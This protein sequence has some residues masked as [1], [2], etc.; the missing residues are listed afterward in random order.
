LIAPVCL[1]YN[2]ASTLRPI[3]HANLEELMTFA[4]I[5]WIKNIPVME[6]FNLLKP[7]RT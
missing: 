3:K 2:V 5:Y 6:E 4:W 7:Q 1:V